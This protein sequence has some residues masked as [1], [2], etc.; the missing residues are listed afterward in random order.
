MQPVSPCCLCKGPHNTSRCPELCD[1][2]KE[3]FYSGGAPP[4]GGH[5]HDDEKCEREP[6]ILDTVRHWIQMTD[7]SICYDR[8][9]KATGRSVMSCGHEFH[10]R[11]LAQWLQRPDGPG[12]CPCC[13]KPPGELE[14]LDPVTIVWKYHI[15]Q[16]PPPYYQVTIAVMMNILSMFFIQYLF[17]YSRW[18]GGSYYTVLS[19]FVLLQ[20]SRYQRFRLW[21]LGLWKSWIMVQPCSCESGLKPRHWIQHDWLC[22]LLWRVDGGHGPLCDE[23]WTWV[24]HA[25]PCAV[26]AK[27]RR[28]W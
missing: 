28:N 18:F 4:S 21:I 9:T 5:D 6:N 11:C 12:T 16:A 10:M 22:N 2:L 19:V 7:C 17:S 23:L 13:R 20:A 14:I 3:G 27:A 15:I 26:A 25:M 24:P 8:V 1:P